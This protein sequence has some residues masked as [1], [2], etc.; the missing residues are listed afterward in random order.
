MTSQSFRH[1]WNR[2]LILIIS[3]SVVVVVV[4]VVVVFN[5]QCLERTGELGRRMMRRRRQVT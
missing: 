2:D 5:L 3:S 4:V 1:W